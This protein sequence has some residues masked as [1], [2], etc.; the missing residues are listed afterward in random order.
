MAEK[1]PGASRP[2]ERTHG[3]R[4]NQSR[5]ASVGVGRS[6]GTGPINVKTA[7]TFGLTWSSAVVL[8]AGDSTRM[9]T[10]KALL[11]APDGQP[12]V[13]RISRAFADAGVERVAVVTGVGPRQYCRGCCGR[14]HCRR[15]VRLV[16][17]PDPGRGQL[18]SLWT[19][20]DAAVAP[21]TEALLMTLVDVPMLSAATVE[22]VVGEWRRTQA[23]IVRPAS[24]RCTGTRC[25]SIGRSSTSCARRRSRAAPRP[26]CDVTRRASST[27]C[28]PTTAACATSTRPRTMPPPA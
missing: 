22:A 15:P 26:W 4:T 25:S 6:V 16:R 7:L 5:T 21:D 28:R 19:G 12:F 1:I 27:S 13:V 9:G 14:R 8:A 18:S 23:P 24:G 17:N 11:A 3:P 2:P 20:M 10:P